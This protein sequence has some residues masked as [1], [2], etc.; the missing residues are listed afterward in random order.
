[1]ALSDV[2][3]RHY[4]ETEDLKIHP[5]ELNDIQPASVDFHLDTWL[6]V[7]NLEH[8]AIDPRADQ[9]RISQWFEID[10]LYYR[11]AGEF[12]LG[13]TTEQVVISGFHVG[14]VGG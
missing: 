3:I 4:L 13:Q 8:E 5:L 2:T 10:Q 14:Q 9:E 1:M 12:I 7:L 6:G 11:Q